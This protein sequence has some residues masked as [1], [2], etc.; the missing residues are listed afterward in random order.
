MIDYDTKTVAKKAHILMMNEFLPRAKKCGQTL[1]EFI[2]SEVGAAFIQ[3][4]L[5]G[6]F[7]R[8]D[9]R[10]LLDAMVELRKE[11]VA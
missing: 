5:S 4:E 7:T 8:R 3:A 10:Q 9:T 2:P 1:S 6:R 11:R